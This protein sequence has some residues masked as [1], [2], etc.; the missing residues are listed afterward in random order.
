MPVILN[1][2]RLDLVKEE[3]AKTPEEAASELGLSILGIIPENDEILLQCETNE[4]LV[5][6]KSTACRSFVNIARRLQGESVPIDLR[7]A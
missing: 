4:D 1:R 7:K 6:L 5:H 2:V 3:L